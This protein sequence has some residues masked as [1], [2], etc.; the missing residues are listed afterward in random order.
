M[1]K[2]DSE[3]SERNFLFAGLVKQNET[4]LTKSLEDEQKTLLGREKHKYDVHIHQSKSI[5]RSGDGK[6]YHGYIS[7]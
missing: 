2:G 7:N 5:R 6:L 3:N 4:T 1:Q